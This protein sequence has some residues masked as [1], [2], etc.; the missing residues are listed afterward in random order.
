MYV[1]SNSSLSSSLLRFCTAFGGVTGGGVGG[2]SL[3][4]RSKSIL[5]LRSESLEQ[6]DEK[7]AFLSRRAPLEWTGITEGGWLTV[8]RCSV[9]GGS[10]RMTFTLLSGDLPASWVSRTVLFDDPGLQLACPPAAFSPVRCFSPCG[11]LRR[12]WSRMGS[13]P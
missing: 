8:T 2:F 1:S 12:S 3:A 10:F 7:L 13:G 11:L 5:F 4:R 9:V 6:F